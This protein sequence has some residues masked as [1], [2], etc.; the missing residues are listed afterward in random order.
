MTA[1]P[2]HTSARWHY[3]RLL[4]TPLPPQTDSIDRLT[5]LQLVERAAGEW[6]GA[7]GAPG[8]GTVEV[9][10]ILSASEVD[11][12]KGK[13]TEGARE[14]VIRFPASALPALLTALPLSP[15]SSYRLE[16]LSHSSDLQRV[17]GTGTGGGRASRGKRG[18]AKWV[19]G[20]KSGNGGGEAMVEG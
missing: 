7:A 10:A 3:A 20:L 2:Q 18:Y 11:G 17:A 4:L 14:A 9:V 8:R 13:G 6:Y 12:T 16:I 1:I 15:S 19:Q 5:L